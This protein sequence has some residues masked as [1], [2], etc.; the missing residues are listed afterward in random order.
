MSISKELYAKRGSG[1]NRV[2]VTFRIDKELNDFLSKQPNKNEYI[3]QI[4]KE[5]A[6]L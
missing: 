3:N 4:L 6:G 5:K 1:K 2:A